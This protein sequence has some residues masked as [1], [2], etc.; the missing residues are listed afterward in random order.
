M[1]N[2][3]NPINFQ[4][5]AKKALDLL[6]QYWGYAQLR[7][8]QAEVIK[9]AVLGEHQI[10][11]MPTGAG[12]SLCY[13]LP[14]VYKNGL[15]LVVSPLISLMEDQVM[16]L[17]DLGIPSHCIHSGC[18][19]AAIQEALNKAYHQTLRVLYVSPER[20]LH[21]VFKMQLEYLKPMLCVIDEAHCI[22]EWGFDFR[23]AFLDT[24]MVRVLFPETPVMALTATANQKVI[25]DIKSVLKIPE[26]RVHSQAFLRSNLQYWKCE[27]VPD[28]NTIVEWLQLVNGP[29]LIYFRSRKKTQYWANQLRLKGYA[30]DFYH[31]GRSVKDRKNIQEY[32]LQDKI[33]VL[34]ATT[35][36]GMGVDKP[37]VRLVLH[38]DVPESPE[39]YY[40]ESGRA[41]RD[42][43]RSYAVLFYNKSSYSA[44]KNK[45][46]A[47]FPPSEAIHTV[48]KTLY[49]HA[50]ISYGSG[51][52]KRIQINWD[53]FC[54]QYRIQISD[55]N[56]MLPHLIRF[57]YLSIEEGW[58]RGSR[59]KLS[60][61]TD[62][63]NEIECAAP[64]KNIITALLR[65]YPDIK[66][67]FVKISESDIAALCKL[68]TEALKGHLLSMQTFQWL[69]YEPR[70]NQ[71][72][73]TFLKSRPDQDYWDWPH[74]IY[75]EL[76]HNQSERL[77]N[78]LAYLEQSNG[79]LQSFLIRSFIEN[80]NE[81]CSTCMHCQRIKIQNSLKTFLLEQFKLKPRQV[82]GDLKKNLNVLQRIELD[83]VLQELIVKE[84]L[85]LKIDP[86]L[87]ENSTFVLTS[88]WR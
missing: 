49:S 61:D 23:P 87:M 33:Q 19:E 57:G 1:S 42:G 84:H 88:L 17:S 27:T 59:L 76:K 66:S 16:K 73:L 22:S 52:L 15:V 24:G 56:L 18:S 6:Q 41:G 26:A 55:L 12:K 47:R 25:S 78:L 74:T 29:T 85:A 79:C 45:L 60:L 75:R 44:L 2:Y 46:E 35:A 14:A 32:W 30:T 7:G 54:E 71:L 13:Q 67:G 58:N 11:L 51:M 31:A 63:P 9:N 82:V 69:L 21:P 4:W 5:N 83:G 50:Q 34:C 20:L 3:T 68:S 40:Q 53:A 86:V 37:N 64:F 65:L 62:Y 80:A 43:A 48:L 10:V 36:F 8:E 28:V 70:Q 77:N 39:S 38:A 81:D 72:F